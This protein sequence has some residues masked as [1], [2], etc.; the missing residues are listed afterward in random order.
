VR[1]ARRRPALVF[2]ASAALGLGAGACSDAEK[3]QEQ[4]LQQLI[5]DNYSLLRQ[6][7]SYRSEEQQEAI[8]RFQRLGP[9]QGGEV[10]VWFLNDPKAVEDERVQVLLA[11][12]LADW[13][14]RRAVPFL[15]E[16]FK[17]RDGGVLRIA[18]EGLRVFDQDPALVHALGEQLGGSRHEVRL[19]AANVLASFRASTQAQELLGRRLKDEENDEVRAVCL[20]GVVEGP[21]GAARLGYLIDA[22]GDPDAQIRSTAWQVLRREG[23]PEVYQP[24]AALAARVE[25][26][27]ALKRWAGGRPRR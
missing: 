10:V 20:L 24:A 15:V 11:R 18:E 26:I 2:L 9:A 17:S 13:R 16:S 1:A 4:S 3:R 12:I 5:A 27:V 19:S 21:R 7:G 14:D 22:L 25:G 8:E 23:A 6:L